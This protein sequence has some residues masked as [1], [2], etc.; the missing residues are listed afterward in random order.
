[1][2]TTHTSNISYIDETLPFL[3]DHIE[4]IILGIM[5]E[6]PENITSSVYRATTIKCFTH[7]TYRKLYK[8]IADYVSKNG[9]SNLSFEAI[10]MFY[11]GEDNKV[12]DLKIA[13]LLAELA[14][15]CINF[16]AWRNWIKWLH[17]SYEK[18]LF[19]Q[20]K[21][22]KDFENAQIKIEA[23][24]IKENFN[25][26]ETEPDKYISSY[27][28][29]KNSLIKT[30]YGSLDA[31]LGGFTKGNLIILAARPAMG[32]TVTALNLATTLALHNIS[33]LFIELEMTPNEIMQRINSNILNIPAERLR[34]RTLTDDELC[35]F[36]NY[37]ISEKGKQF[38]KLIKIPAHCKPNITEIENIIKNAQEDVIFLDHIGLVRGEAKN[39]RYEA[40]TE[41]VE[42]IKTLAL[43]IEKPIIALCQ[44]SRAV[45]T[46][47]D[48]RPKLSDLRDSGALEQ[49]ADIVLFV[50][51]EAYYN[52]SLNKNKL[53]LIIGKSRSTGGAGEIINL[54][55][56]GDYQRITDPLGETKEEYTQCKIV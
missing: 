13:G 43:E 25:T 11:F 44:L 6:A 51:R 38:N 20:C 27:D 56:N 29:D 18:R 37:H 1:M 8:I 47:E 10:E 42:R 52:P 17:Q 34:N 14:N 53:E 55:Y 19:A 26:L 3:Q 48:T 46:R 30:Y 28:S 35:K 45:T 33:S 12:I 39:S 7:P 24:K 21:T 5:L 50:H 41:V 4:R 32:K 22:L 16:S 36:Q 15:E 23:L 40:T 2:C 54:I 31:K 49:S 9:F